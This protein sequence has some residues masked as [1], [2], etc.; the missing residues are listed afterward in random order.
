MRGLK[1]G[2]GSSEIKA[3]NFYLPYFGIMYEGGPEFF[4]GGGFEFFLHKKPFLLHPTPS[5]DWSLNNGNT[6]N[7]FTLE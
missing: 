4:L 7:Y 1:E 5:N 6:S 3:R 2:W